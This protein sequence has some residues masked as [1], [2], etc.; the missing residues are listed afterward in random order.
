[1]ERRETSSIEAARLQSAPIEPSWVISGNPVARCA[2]LSRSR[3]RTAATLLWD[4]TAGEFDWNYSDDETVH[5]LEGEAIVDDG[6]GPRTM[7]PGDVVHFSA[8]TRWRWRVPAYVKKV[9]F[10]RA[11]AP[12][13]LVIA[14]KAWR[15]IK[16]L[17][18]AL[19]LGGPA[20][21]MA[22]LGMI[23]IEI[24]G[25]AQD[26]GLLPLALLA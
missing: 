11:T 26:P 6:S 1:M 19:V 18:R 14:L 20:K 3:D 17:P 23:C 24:S 25:L 13:P 15:K 10:L 22:G 12:L 16:S 2:E 21:G 7:K 8:G 5:I 9:A 4:C